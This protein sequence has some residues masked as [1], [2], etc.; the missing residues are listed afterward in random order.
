VGV[1]KDNKWSKQFDIRSIA[2]VDGFFNHIRQVAAMCPPMRAHWWQAANWQ[3][4]M[5]ILCP[6]RVHNP[7]GKSIGS[8]IFTAHR[9][10][11][12]ASAVLATAIPSVRHTPVLC[13][14]G[15]T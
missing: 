13:Q 5:C 11:R 10:A 1:A 12:I 4:R 2:A 14:N 9:N 15:G 8:A 3:I 6:T 7:N